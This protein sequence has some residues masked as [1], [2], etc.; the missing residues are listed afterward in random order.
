MLSLL[1]SSLART[2]FRLALS[3]GLLAAAPALFG[4]QA[5]STGLC[6]QQ[7]SCPNG[8]TTSITGKVYAPNGVDPLPN[9]LVYI[10]N[11]PVGAFPATV[12][13]TVGG[14]VPSGSPIVGTTTGI[15]GSFLL[16]NVPVGSNIPVVIQTGRWRRQVT[17]STVTACASNAFSTRFA[18][19][20]AEGDIPKIA[21]AT[22]AE[23]GLE[24]VLRKVGLADSE[25]TSA[26]GTGR[27]NFFAGSG[28][29]GATVDASTTSEDSLMTNPTQLAGYDIVMFPCQGRAYTKTT[30]MQN[31]LIDYANTGGRVYATHFSYVW[32]YN[33]PPFSGTANWLGTSSNLA[34]GIATIDTTYPNGQ[35]LA[36]WLQ[37]IGATTTSGQIAISTLRHDQSGIVSPPSQSVLTLNTTGN[38]VM[39]FTFETPVGAPAASQCGKVL[40]N[41]YHVEN[42]SA[43]LTGKVF[44]AECPGGAM[45]PQ[46]KLLE[47]SLFD[48]SGSSVIPTLTPL[49]Q[50]FGQEPVGI[51]SATHTFVV[52]NPSPFPIAV[53]GAVTT[54]DFAIVT[55]NCAAVVAGGSCQITVSFTPTT[56]G[57]RTGT[58]SVTSGLTTLK[59][60]LTGTGVPD[61][62][63]SS[64]S[65]NFGNIDIGGVSASQTVT[66][67]NALPS[68]V[69][70][71]PLTLTGDYTDTTTCGA[72]LGP[73]AT[74]TVTIVFR[75]TATGPRPGSLVI[76]AVNPAYGSATTTLTGNGVD[77]SL[78]VAPTS[79][80]VI[81]GLSTG[82]TATLAP[83]G[84]FNAIVTLSCTT[85]APGSTCKPGL[86]SAT[87]SSSVA[88]Q[89]PITT[90]AKYT[91]VGYGGFGGGL[92]VTLFGAA[93]GTLVWSIRRRRGNTLVR[94]CLTVLLLAGIGTW[95]TGCSGKLPDLNNPYTAPGTY[96][97]TLTASDGFL[98]HTA[99]YSLTV[100]AK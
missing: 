87:V 78:V 96:T 63:V 76:T 46:E 36:D 44:P 58:L 9:V 37:N 74:C 90:T 100:T 10:P 52:S 86:S 67:T 14:V 2:P 53:S 65:L 34:D 19:T 26:S 84:G 17:V 80:S 50:D 18:A 66:V 56:I 12:G 54:G 23:D 48:L 35:T 88:V 92:L 64:S 3:L 97:Y 98:T 77:F 6:L 39:Q 51:T 55:N 11:A 21:I 93:G 1:V 22:G 59:S 60:T 20:S 45:T 33:D 24:C 69:A 57:A 15:D 13:C 25:F 38:P 16:A 49:T 83:I 89:V 71:Q 32:L 47:F 82:T 94:A 81:A 4:Q 85:N 31:N 75:P 70:L 41:E 62:Q 99:T 42:P 27:I 73:Q 43:A 7:V 61:I 91:V 79:G 95:T 5:C 72:S 28:A 29:A 40:F 8:G 68:T 30:A